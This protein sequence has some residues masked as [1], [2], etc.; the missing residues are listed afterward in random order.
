MKR[1]DHVDELLGA[2]KA[3]DR[4]PKG[5]GRRRR[6]VGFHLGRNNDFIPIRKIDGEVR[7]PFRDIEDCQGVLPAIGSVPGKGKDAQPPLEIRQS[8]LCLFRIGPD[9]ECLL[10]DPGRG[11]DC[12]HQP[13]WGG[14]VDFCWRLR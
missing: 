9:P 7:E 13:R 2:R 5:P 4:F 8:S 10:L 12:C 14:V 11:Y 3:A 6:A 1:T